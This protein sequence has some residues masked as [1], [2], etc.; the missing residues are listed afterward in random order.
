[1]VTKFFVNEASSFYSLAEKGNFQK[2]FRANFEIVQKEIYSK[3][4][5]CHLWRKGNIF[6]LCSWSHA[7]LEYKVM[8]N[9]PEHICM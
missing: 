2:H 4:Q 7:S 9:M 8:F 6:E 1:M 3:Q 5:I